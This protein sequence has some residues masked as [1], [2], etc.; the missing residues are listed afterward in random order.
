MQQRL[1]TQIEEY[2]AALPEEEKIDALN[3]FRQAL[4]R[5]SPFHNQPVDCVLW[6][7]EE[8]VVPND[9]NPNNLAPPEKRLLLTSLEAN[10][11]TQPIVVQNQ[12]SKRYTIVDGF[13]RHELAGSKLSLKKQLKGYLPVTC[14][15]A[16]SPPARCPDSRDYPPQPGARAP[17]DPRDVGNC[18]R[19]GQSRLE[20]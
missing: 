2:L 6:V 17:S 11:F 18:P 3:H 7:K 14:L 1:I 13:H 9:Y 15:S 5:H 10:G 4:H 8:E 20:Q 19:A 12:Q 16:N